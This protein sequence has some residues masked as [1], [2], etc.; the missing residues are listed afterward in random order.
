M[1]RKTPI[2]GF[3]LFY[4]DES[5]I[6][7]E[8]VRPGS[9]YTGTLQPDPTNTLNYNF[10]LMEDLVQSIL[11]G[12]L[13]FTSIS[14]VQDVIA[15]RDVVVGRQLILNPEYG[16]VLN[17]DHRPSPHILL[18]FADALVYAGDADNT[19]LTVTAAGNSITNGTQ[20]NP[21]KPDNSVLA[22]SGNS[23]Y[24][25]VFLVS[26]SGTLIDTSLS[27]K[28]RLYLSF[29][30]VP[31]G[32]SGVRLEASQDGS[33]F[34]TIG[35]YT[36]DLGNKY[37]LLGPAILTG[38]AK[39]VRI[40]LEGTNSTST[41]FKI[42]RVALLHEGTPALEGFYLPRAGGS[43]Y[44]NVN[45]RG[46]ITTT[47]AI[48]TRVIQGHNNGEILVNARNYGVELRID[49]DATI[50][51]SFKVTR[52]PNGSTTLMVVHSSGN[53]GVGT[54]APTQKLDVAGNIRGAQFIST[55][56]TGT[57]PFQVSSSTKVVNL[58]AD[59]LDGYD[60]ADFPRKD[61]NATIRGTWTFSGAPT[62]SSTPT[63]RAGLRV[64]D[65][66]GLWTTHGW[67]KAIDLDKGQ[68]LVWRTGGGLSVGLGVARTTNRIYFA[69][70]T[71]EDA[72]TDPSYPI[73][74]DVGSG[75]ILF[76]LASSSIKLSGKRTI[77]VF[78]DHGG[79]T[80]TR[81]YYLGK[82][83]KGA[84]ILKVQG[85]M[86]GHTWDQGRANV[87]LQFSARDGFRVDGEV[88]GNV[89]RA[90]IYVY[91][92][93]GDQYIYIYLV[94]KTW[95]LVNLELSATGYS[96]V[97]EYNG[98]YTTTEPTFGGSPITP[99]F[100]LSNGPSSNILWT[101]NSGALTV[102]AILGRNTGELL[103][104]GR[105]YGVEVRVDEDATSYDAFRV[106]RGSGGSTT[107]MVVQSGGSVGI[108]T[109][110]P[111]QKLDVA[112]NIKG[113]QFISTAS[114]GTSPMVV[115]STTTVINLSAD[116][117]DGLH[118]SQFL[119]SDADTTFNGTTL[120][121]NGNIIMAAGKTVDGVDISVFKSAYDVHEHNG[122]DAPKV[123]AENV[124]SQPYNGTSYSTTVKAYLDSLQTQINNLIQGAQ[125]ADTLLVNH[126]TV[127]NTIS[128]GTATATVSALTV[129]SNATVKG[130]LIVEGGAGAVAIKEG[131]SDS[132][133]GYLEKV[134]GTL[135]LAHTSTNPV[136]VYRGTT[137]G[138]ADFEIFK[139]AGSGELPIYLRFHQTTR[140]WESIK[141]TNGLISFVNGN[142]TDYIDIK[143]RRV[144]ATQDLVVAGNTIATPSGIPYA[145]LPALGNRGRDILVDRVAVWGDGEYPFA[146][147]LFKSDGWFIIPRHI[148]YGAFGQAMNGSIGPRSGATR[149][150]RIYITGVDNARDVYDPANQYW[151]NGRTTGRPWVRLIK[152][153]S[154]WDGAL[155]PT[156]GGGTNIRTYVLELPAAFLDGY[157]Q[158]ALGIWWDGNSPSWP[159][160][161]VSGDTAPNNYLNYG[162]DI[163]WT[164]YQAWFETYDRY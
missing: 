8:D 10:K 133:P 98:N 79:D 76:T 94:T 28:V 80:N 12:R 127:N 35:Y 138:Q 134:G 75:D 15:G 30:T 56:T 45:V 63:T 19:T 108:G 32:I 151:N 66:A 81:Y 1:P 154:T 31:Q 148:Y 95:A 6:S 144:T 22:L 105:N 147:E 18:D 73:V 120:T 17:A 161:N 71:A 41:N 37:L 132:T 38:S 103:V 40:T 100:K 13:A 107:L 106:T 11:N 57:A 64:A 121:V 58:N 82:V 27:A 111:T 36:R 20:K 46:N 48:Q 93:S 122:T 70:S 152:G 157:F 25:V 143:A 119:R 137:A 88:I 158:I 156:W 99:I 123:K 150:L 113:T 110:S 139:D 59:L 163:Q 86:G 91:D 39:A 101:D 83:N 130:D 92:P 21:F 164:I 54:A 128:A 97:I 96:A 90:D 116:M 87:D 141:A 126:L 14:T 65:G 78:V 135:R 125:T 118:S 23:V 84:G 24:P 129:N 53:V 60:S 160:A 85:I 9:A 3:N 124:L 72:S 146:L 55:A 104:S 7:A 69:S 50:T 159:T 26:S 136:T 62:F 49:E 102:P 67:H 5:I 149:V 47:G 142:D 4:H 52:G 43:V 34:T 89:G 114:S 29:D 131:S 117:V 153:S 16:L 42:R 112:G 68:A 109:T 162:A 155:T 115:N 74:F 145:P 33:T 44:G 51:D 61:E 77:D 2:Y 140:H